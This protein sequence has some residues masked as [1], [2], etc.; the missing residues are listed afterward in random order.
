MLAGLSLFQ[1]EALRL[2]GRFLYIMDLGT[3]VSNIKNMQF[4]G[5]ENISFLIF[6]KFLLKKSS[7]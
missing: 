7:L 6:L 2:F 4:F 3:L 1:L 5:G